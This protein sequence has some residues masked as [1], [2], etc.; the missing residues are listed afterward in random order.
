MKQLFNYFRLFIIPVGLALMVS[1]CV[2]NEYDLEGM[3]GE[4]TIGEGLVLPLAKTEQI[5]LEDVLSQSKLDQLSVGAD[6]SIGFSVADKFSL[7]DE[8]SEIMSD[9]EF[10]DI[11]ISR[12][13]RVNLGVVEIEDLPEVPGL[14]EQSGSVSLGAYSTEIE[15]TVGFE[16]F[17]AGSSDGLV[18]IKEVT[19]DDVYLN[20]SLTPSG[21]PDL[22][23]DITYDFQLTLPDFIKVEDEY[24][25]EDGKLSLKGVFDEDGKKLR[26]KVKCLDLTDYDITKN[27]REQITID[28]TVFVEDL[29]VELGTAS[30]RFGFALDVDLHD[31]AISKAVVN[32][33]YDVEGFRKSFDFGDFTDV[34]GEDAVLDMMNTHLVLDVKTNMTIPVDGS[35]ILTPYKNGTALK[36]KVL[37]LNMSLP[38]AESSAKETARK[39][40]ICDNDE[41]CPAG[42]TYLEADLSGLINLLPE[43]IEVSV[44][45]GTDPEVDAVVEFN[46][47]YVMDVNYELNVP[48]VFGNDLYLSFEYALENLSMPEML[49]EILNT[50]SNAVVLQ[51]TIESSIP[52]Q[53]ELG[54]VLL[55]AEGEVVPLERSEPSVIKACAQDG[56]ATESEFEIHI[57]KKS[58]TPDIKSVAGL[59]LVFVGTSPNISGV[60]VCADD[61][62]QAFIKLSLPEG[63]TLDTDTI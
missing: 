27:I 62:I 1:S 28:G 52:L 34:L 56:S 39:Y 5:K 42:H 15:E 60:P 35:I 61:Y 4:M 38:Y 26:V 44:E 24:L 23:S 46:S 43:K 10:Q 37:R 51:G 20:V 14:P 29:V 19:L 12:N 30:E 11:T 13:V 7:G 50:G 25:D 36:D 9:L 2:K 21:L 16:V 48:M 18:Q 59:E 6:G 41:N 55:D 31:I 54:V 22:G 57:Q 58:G 49:P 17:V 40:F 47:D 45:V 8:L 63:L 32:V 3:E 33:D 53:L